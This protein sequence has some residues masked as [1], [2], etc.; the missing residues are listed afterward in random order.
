MLSRNG[1]RD[2]TGCEWPQFSPTQDYYAGYLDDL[3]ELNRFTCTVLT[4]YCKSNLVYSKLAYLLLLKTSFYFTVD[5]LYGVTMLSKVNLLR[6]RGVGRLSLR[7]FASE[8]IVSNIEGSTGQNDSA[9]SQTG[10]ARHNV[11][12]AKNLYLGKFDKVN[13]TKVALASPA[14]FIVY[15][16]YS[17]WHSQWHWQ[18]HFNSLM[19]NLPSTTTSQYHWGCIDIHW[20]YIYMFCFCGY[21]QLVMCWSNKLFCI[22]WKKVKGGLG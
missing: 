4:A 3:T 7:S 13:I 21:L 20:H 12:F 17:H 14:F 1:T 18:T 9:L 15:S 8:P 11:P 6:L 10:K 2:V 5:C 16:L 22:L 19:S